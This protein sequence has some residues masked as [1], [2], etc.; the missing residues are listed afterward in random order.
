MIDNTNSFRVKKA[1]GVTMMLMLL[2]FAALPTVWVLIMSFREQSA[3][4]EPIWESPLA[5]TL[6]SYRGIAR[7]DFP[8]AL[9]NSFICAGSATLLAMIVGVPAGFALAKSRL[10]GK[11]Y[12]SWLL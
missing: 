3:I 11:F 1:L 12:A 8:K 4:F 7:S 9:L 6:D 10:S 5:V 2:F